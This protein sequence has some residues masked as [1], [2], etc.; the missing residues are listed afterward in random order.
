MQGTPAE[1]INQDVAEVSI[2]QTDD[3]TD[4]TCERSVRS[5]MIR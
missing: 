4:E 5:S 1:L 3:V 2:S